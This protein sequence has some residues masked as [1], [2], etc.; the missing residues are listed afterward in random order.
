[1]SSVYVAAPTKVYTSI[2]DL[3]ENTAIGDGDRF[4]VQSSDGETALL[5]YSQIKINLDHT[6]FGSQ[7]SEMIEFTSNVQQWVSQMTNEFNIMEDEFADIKETS[8]SLTNQIAAIKVVLKLMMGQRNAYSEEAINEWISGQLT[9]SYA[10][11][12]FD[13]LIKA[14]DPSFTFSTNNLLRVY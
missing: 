2:N 4:I 3:P 7:F 5:D 12:Q 14:N 6:T 13:E 9:D 11:E 10:K 1:M 8:Q